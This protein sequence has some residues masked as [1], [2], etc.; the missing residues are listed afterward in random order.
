MKHSTKIAIASGL[1]ASIAVMTSFNPR[2]FMKT[3]NVSEPLVQR[4]FASSTPHFTEIQLGEFDKSLEGVRVK[5]ALNAARDK[6]VYNL[7]GD[8]CTS[9]VGIQEVAV[10][11][12][13]IE[14]IEFLK[15]ILAMKA[16][17]LIREK[18]A[19]RKSPTTNSG[20]SA[21]LLT[22]SNES[23]KTNCEMEIEDGLLSCQ[24][25][26]IMD[27]ISKCEDLAK[28]RA[29]CFKNVDRY[30]AR[31]FKRNIT[32][33]LSAPI[34]SDLFIEASEIRDDLIRD[35]PSRFDNTIRSQLISSTS[36]GV[37][38]RLNQNYN[39]ALMTGAAPGFAATQAKAQMAN[40]LNFQNRF[41]V[42]GQLLQSLLA[43]AQDSKLT[44]IYV[45]Q[46]WFYQS[47]YNPLMKIWMQDHSKGFSTE[48]NTHVTQNS[49]LI[50]GG[51]REIPTA[52]PGLQMPEGLAQRRTSPQATRQDL[53]IVNPNLN[54]SNS[55]P[56]LQNNQSLHGRNHDS[57][58]APQFQG[59]QIRR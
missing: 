31:F 17:E 46:T 59:R 30:F 38:A 7:E 39:M 24:R 52:V 35:L 51:N 12:R 57:S 18:N 8:I 1:L 47:F 9:C 10:D 29:T 53:R 37:L 11:P 3:K 41:S 22:H 16:M 26:E 28:E 13:D 58:G 36:D 42:G 27:M 44:D 4:E 48:F 33:G 43:Y 40:E 5:A 23:F 54:S 15:R 56:M 14:N 25:D 55:G 49:T 50:D 32:K 19:L 20:A 6:A 2:S 21:R 34:G 45:A